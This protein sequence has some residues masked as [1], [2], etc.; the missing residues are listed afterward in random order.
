[1]IYIT[2]DIKINIVDMY[3]F[4]AFWLLLSIIFIMHNEV[5]STSSFYVTPHLFP[6]HQMLMKNM[7]ID[8]SIVCWWIILNVIH[9]LKSLPEKLQLN[10][11]R[12]T[13]G[14]EKHSWKK[15]S[16]MLT[17]VTSCNHK[18]AFSFGSGSSNFLC[19]FVT[20]TWGFC[21]NLH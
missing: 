3:Y 1:M 12:W 5:V 11:E 14:I 20:R 19:F 8:C 21:W 4:Y 18:S 9:W 13:L 15:K 2:H 10:A 17:F 16:S 7:P 6:M